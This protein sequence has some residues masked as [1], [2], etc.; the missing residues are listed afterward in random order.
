MRSSVAVV[1]LALL[2]VVSGCSITKG[3]LGPSETV[4]FPTPGTGSAPSATLFLETLPGFGNEF[5]LVV[6]ALSG[7]VRNAIQLERALSGGESWSGAKLCVQDHTGTG[8]YVCGG[9]VGNPERFTINHIQTAGRVEISLVF[10]PGKPP[11]EP[12]SRIGVLLNSD[13]TEVGSAGFFFAERFQSS[14][15]RRLSGPLPR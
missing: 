14:Y 13:N 6:S 12:V 2:V 15:Y 9:I 1:V 7:S 4:V 8:F 3:S 5:M 10:E 11:G